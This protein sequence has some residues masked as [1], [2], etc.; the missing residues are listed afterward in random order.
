MTRACRPQGFVEPV[1]RN[2]NDVASSNQ[3]ASEYLPRLG[4][5]IDHEAVM[6]SPPLCE[7]TAV[8]EETGLADVLE[9]Q[10]HQRV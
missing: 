10:Q 8:A 6:N 9:T 5:L 3:G 2:R 1:F 4:K 7:D